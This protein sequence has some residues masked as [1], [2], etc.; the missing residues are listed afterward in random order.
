MPEALAPPR[1]TRPAKT[2]ND[3]S[4]DDVIAMFMMLRSMP[5]ESHEYQRQREC[6]VTRCLPLADH[7]ARHFGR[8]GEGL[9]DLTQVARLGLMNAINRFDPDKG[10][11]FIGFAIPTMMG[12]VRRHFRDYSWGM[13][14]PR[15]LRE[16]HV[17][18]GRATGDLVQKLGRAPTARELSAELGVPHDEIVECLVAGDA[19]QLDSLDAPV[20]PDDSGNSRRIADAVGAVDPQIDH[21]TDREAVRSLVTALP[22]REREVLHMRFFESMTQS[23]I[24]ERIGVSQMQ[25]S[26]ILANT[27]T[28]LRDQLD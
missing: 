1:P 7:V 3:D 4:Y 20:G 25:V 21:I 24:A 17:Q 10:P 15:R 26:R 22:Q 8:R 19:Y 13:R 28:A 5:A 14:V 16:L 6:I 9:D 18:I 12:E 11:S 27:L 2:R 23:Q